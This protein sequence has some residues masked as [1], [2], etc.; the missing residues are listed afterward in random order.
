MFVVWERKSA[1]KGLQ[2]GHTHLL[3]SV[4]WLTMASFLKTFRSVPQSLATLNGY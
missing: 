1:Q 4:Q 3:S 2:I